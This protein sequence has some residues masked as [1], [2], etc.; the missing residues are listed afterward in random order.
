[1]EPLDAGIALLALHGLLGAFDTLYN[2]EWDARLPE[3]PAAA[4]EL[5]LHAGR[6]ALYAAV[7]AGLAWFEWHGA[8]V[9]LLAALVACEF[10]L[11][12]VDSVVE[13]R[14]R[15]VSATERVV[16]MILG[17]T[18]GAW[19][20]FVFYT[21]FTDWWSRPT[22]LTGTGYGVVSWLL[23]AYALGAA[24]SSLRDAMTSVRLER[25]ARYR[26]PTSG[27]RRPA[28]VAGR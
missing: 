7:F 17:V 24:L 11:T 8:F 10:W 4:R 1:M 26:P 15:D 27:S 12:L 18:T 28:V 5:R 22:A 2:H 23:T 25:L 20:G 14:T 13:D 21:G 19:S 3:H 6:S 16:H 9:A